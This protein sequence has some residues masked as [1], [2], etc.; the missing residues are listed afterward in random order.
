MTTTATSANASNASSF[1]ALK[2]TQKREQQQHVR[3]RKQQLRLLKA[4]PAWHPENKNDVP[5]DEPTPG[6]SSL[7]S[8]LE[9]IKKGKFVVV[10]DDEDREN[11][12]DLIG[13]AE[14]MTQ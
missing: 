4:V 8:A 13:A 11:E 14:L 7:P 2:S 10:L 5:F 12:G 1:D 6:F 9:E 3:S